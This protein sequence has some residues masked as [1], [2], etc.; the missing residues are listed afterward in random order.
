VRGDSGRGKNGWEV[1][2]EGGRI[3]PWRW[4]HGGN[5]EGGA[6]TSARDVRKCHGSMEAKNESRGKNPTSVPPIIQSDLKHKKSDL[7][8][9]Q[10]S[11]II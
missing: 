7:K 1:W 10:F 11:F 3:T 4:R 5:G 9:D 8:S 6:I 2:M